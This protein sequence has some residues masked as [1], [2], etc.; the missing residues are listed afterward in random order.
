MCAQYQSQATTAT[1]DLVTNIVLRNDLSSV[2]VQTT[3]AIGSN[4]PNIENAV[5]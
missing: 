1:V 2:A 5:A 4:V 3:N